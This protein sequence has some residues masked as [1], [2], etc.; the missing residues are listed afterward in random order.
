MEKTPTQEEQEGAMWWGE[1]IL[2]GCQSRRRKD[3]DTEVKL[4]LI[5]Q[6]IEAKHTIN[7]VVGH[8][9]Y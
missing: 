1:D 4:G 7:L 5:K 9:T 6:S 8:H 2:G 3:L